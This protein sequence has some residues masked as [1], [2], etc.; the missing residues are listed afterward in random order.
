[1]VIERDV[2][3]VAHLGTRGTIVQHFLSMA[4]KNVPLKLQHHNQLN[5]HKVNHHQVNHLQH[6]LHLQHPFHCSTNPT[7]CSTN[8]TSCS[9]TPNSSSPNPTST[10]T[11][12]QHCSTTAQ[13]TNL[14]NYKDEAKNANKKATTSV[15]R[16]LIVLWGKGIFCYVL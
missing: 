1:M 12:T 4:V 14:W 11:T 10:R 5:P 13:P 9:T 15:M 8:P 7:S 2:Q 6:P 16:L 3:F